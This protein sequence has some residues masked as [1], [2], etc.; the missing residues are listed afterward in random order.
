[1]LKETLRLT[2]I[3]PLVARRLTRAATIGGVDQP[4]GA[5]AGACIYLVHRRADLWPVHAPANAR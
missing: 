3:I 1:M 5:V 2:P 4:T